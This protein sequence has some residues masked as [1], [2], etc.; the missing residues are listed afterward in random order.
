MELYD[1]DVEQKKSKAP[2]IIGVCI[3]I[4]VI[5]TILIVLGILYLKNSI[6]TIQIDGIKNNAIE[7]I[8]YFET[9]EEGSQLYIPILKIAKSLGYEGYNGDYKNKSEDKSKCHVTCKDETAMFTLNSDILIKITNDS[10]YEY[11]KLDK[12]VFEK[13]G[14]LYTTIQGIEKAFNIEFDSDEKYKNIKM[15]TMD[16]LIQYYTTNLK[17]QKYSTNFTDKKAIL[18]NMIIIE[19]DNKQFGVINAEN[20]KSVLETKYQ[21]IRYLPATNEFIVKSNG[22]YG[23][24]TK[25]AEIQVKTV[26]DE[27]RTIDN[28]KELYLVKQNNTYGVINTIGEII[29]APDYRQ[30]G[31]D[32]NKYYQNGVVNN[33]I[34]LDEIIPVKND[35][36]LW[37]LFNIKGEKIVDFQY[38][39]VGCQ[40]TPVSNSY[41]VVVIPSHKTIVVEKDKG[42][43]LITMDGRELLPGYILN[44]VYQKINAETEQKEF[45]MT[46][47][48]NTKTMNVEEYLTKI[49]E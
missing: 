16:C 40:S 35:K 44:S 5:M 7:K 43:N 9:T 2:M 12:P 27:I 18:E 8:L 22:K 48:N 38:S 33:Y 11:V 30:I 3:T 17:I 29:I 4:L 25:D 39:N 6:I 41:P 49:G 23:I 37:G 19:D 13:D 26:Y 36:E 15:Y 20:G 10:E 34:L 14:E 47:N 28:R 24:V 32:T 21:E 46:N 42:Y 1:E 45:Y 31:V